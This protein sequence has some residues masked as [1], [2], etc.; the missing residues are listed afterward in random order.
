[1]NILDHFNMPRR[2]LFVYFIVDCSRNMEGSRIGS[3]NDAIENILPLIKNLNDENPDANII[4]KI[5]K[6]NDNPQI[7]YSSD[8]NGFIWQNISASGDLYWG[9]SFNYLTEDIKQNCKTQN[10]DP[11]FVLFSSSPS[12]D[13]WDFHLKRLFNLESFDYGHKIAVAIGSDC[14]PEMLRAFTQRDSH[15]IEVHNIDKIKD[16]IRITWSYPEWDACD[17]D[18]F[19]KCMGDMALI[20]DQS[21]SKFGK[22]ILLSSRI[23]NILSDYN[24]FSLNRA[25]KFIFK[26]I[27][28]DASFERLINSDNWNFDSVSF[29]SRLAQDT[30]IDFENIQQVL[31]SI[32][33]GL[34]QT[35]LLNQ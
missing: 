24:G 33:L 6:A 29:G 16:L 30:G 22:D 20:L 9:R 27:Q 3:V 13:V 19:K 10:Y 35:I 34:K 8:T 32:G 23:I 1:M 26:T 18:D 25:F 12:V 7:V 11:I 5:L 2:D 4:L 31:N 21:I 17:G 28:N 15:I 14:D